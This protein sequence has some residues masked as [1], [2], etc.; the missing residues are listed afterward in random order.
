MGNPILRMVS[1]QIDPNHIKSPEIQQLITD[2]KLTMIQYKGLGIAA[3][4]IGISKRVCL[5][6]VPEYNARYGKLKPVPYTVVI[7]PT[8]TVLSD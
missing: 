4:Q 2:L 6:E 1:E 8:I 3:P 5:I 7:N